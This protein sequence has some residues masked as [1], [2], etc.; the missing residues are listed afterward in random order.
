MRRIVH[1]PRRSIR[2]PQAGGWLPPGWLGALLLALIIT[3]TGCATP[4]TTWESRDLGGHLLVGRK[5]ALPH[6]VWRTH[7]RI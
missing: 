6:V 2:R 3:L 7:E 1:S 5:L 4:E